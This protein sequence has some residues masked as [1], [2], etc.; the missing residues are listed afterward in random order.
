MQKITQFL[1]EAYAELNKVS[2]PTK[3]QAMHYTVLVIA[4]SLIV[5]VV[6]GLLDNTFSS[7][8]KNFILN[9]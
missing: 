2:W 7:L 6:L 9:K 4:I 3:E 5:A 1:K 8:L